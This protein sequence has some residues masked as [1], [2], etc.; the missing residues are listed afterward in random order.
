[1]LELEVKLKELLADTLVLWVTAVVDE[2]LEL[3][4]RVL[5]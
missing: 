2:P 1:M 3:E 4:D 5:L